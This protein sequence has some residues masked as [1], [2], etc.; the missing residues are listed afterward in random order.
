LATSGTPTSPAQDYI[1][2]KLHAKGMDKQKILTLIKF[3]PDGLG[4]GEL[5]KLIEHPMALHAA[6]EEMVTI[7]L[8]LIGKDHEHGIVTTF[9]D[10]AL[11][12]E[13]ERAESLCLRYNGNGQ[14]HASRVHDERI[15]EDVFDREQ[16]SKLVQQDVEGSTDTHHRYEATLQSG[17]GTI[18]NIDISV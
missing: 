2:E 18:G 14:E 10:K 7:G 17:D 4:V 3:I 9:S 5:I 6:L 13:Q 12:E 16:Q 15:S 8:D 11:S 1:W